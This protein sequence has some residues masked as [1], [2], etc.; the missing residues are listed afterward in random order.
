MSSKKCTE[1]Q[2]EQW[3]KEGLG[4][5]TGAGYR[6]WVTVHDFSS[7]GRVHRPY[8]PKFGRKFQLLSDVE[9]GV[10]LLA[11]RAL[12]VVAAEE[13]RPINRE[14]SQAIAKKIGA[15]H[16]TYPSTR[17]PCVMTI[18]LLVTIQQGSE[19]IKIGVDSKTRADAE[20]PVVIEKLEITRACLAD[21]GH[22][23]IVV[24]DTQLP[25]KLIDNLDYIRGANQQPAE[26][27]PY[28]G[29]FE[30]LADQLKAFLSKRLFGNK[31][32]KTLCSEFEDQFGVKTGDGLRA[33]RLLI[34][35][36]V[37]HTDLNSDRVCDLP[38]KVF[39]MEGHRH[40]ASWGVL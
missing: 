20:D 15:R 11:E 9:Y 27:V 3:V 26:V 35:T 40:D 19:Q 1:E 34:E 37:L 6:P 32:L 24:F 17:I 23:H 25:K 39:S 8:S 30:Q 28:P 10:F 16:P 21:R 2:I 14:H 7:R 29:Y 31:Q 4:Q 36:R 38:M 22:R 13:Q 5:G 33:A 18:D 12:N